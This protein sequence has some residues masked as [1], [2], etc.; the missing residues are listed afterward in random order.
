M[1]QP[2][3]LQLSRRRGYSLQATTIAANGLPA[4]NVARPSPWGNPYKSGGLLTRQ[5]CVQAFHE[6]MM[7]AL[8]SR[9]AMRKLLESLR[10]KNLA[11]WCALGDPCHADVLLELANWV[12]EEVRPDA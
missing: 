3:R 12:C 5:E 7:L 1:T 4:V 11:C 10:G 8:E 6:T 9:P 2:V